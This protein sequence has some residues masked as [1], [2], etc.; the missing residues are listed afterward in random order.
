VTTWQAGKDSAGAVVIRELWRL[1]MALFEV[2][3]YIQL[4]YVM[5]GFVRFSGC[6]CLE[7]SKSSDVVHHTLQKITTCDPHNHNNQRELQ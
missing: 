4:L 2:Y 6:G 5:L 3:M 1:I 7:C